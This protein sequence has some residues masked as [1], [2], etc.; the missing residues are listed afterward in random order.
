MFRH[1]L[2]YDGSKIDAAK[3]LRP[4]KAGDYWGTATKYR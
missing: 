4:E 3:M 2:R 1:D